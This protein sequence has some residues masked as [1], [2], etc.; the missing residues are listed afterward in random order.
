M[1]FGSYHMF[2]PIDEVNCKGTLLF[3]DFAARVSV[4]DMDSLRKLTRYS[5]F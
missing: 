4:V 5:S 2:I 1:S 3:L